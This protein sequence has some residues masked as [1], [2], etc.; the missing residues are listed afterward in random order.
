MWLKKNEKYYQKNILNEYINK[1]NGHIHNNTSD[2]I[3]YDSI[4]KQHMR[5]SIDWPLP[6]EIILKPVMSY[7]DLK[8][9]LQFMKPEN[10]Y[11]E[12]G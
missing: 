8:G 5:T 9:F 3:N 2:I 11:F 6:K 12:F 4:I 1:I 7:E 10:I